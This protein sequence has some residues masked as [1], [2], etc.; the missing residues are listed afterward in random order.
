MTQT[1]TK[2]ISPLDPN[3]NASK[4]PDQADVLEFPEISQPEDPPPSAQ[5][6]SGKFDKNTDDS[7][8]DWTD[9]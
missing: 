7:W 9:H 1:E 4:D 5:R 8:K 6:P 3:A 2:D